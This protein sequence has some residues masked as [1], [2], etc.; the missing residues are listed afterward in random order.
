MCSLAQTTNPT[1]GGDRSVTPD[2]RRTG[3]FHALE[4]SPTSLIIAMCL[5]E[6]GV[7]L[8]FG[9][10]PGLGFIILEGLGLRK[11]SMPAL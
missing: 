3:K 10:R 4:T 7:S 1:L 2:T 6:R 8:T 11:R 9:S 5:A